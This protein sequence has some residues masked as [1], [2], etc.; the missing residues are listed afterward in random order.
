MKQRSS[1]I[2]PDSTRFD[3]I[4]I[5][6]LIA[7]LISLITHLALLSSKFPDF[8]G[9]KPTQGRD[10]NNSAIIVAYVP[11]IA[12]RSIASSLETMKAN[13]NSRLAYLC[14][15]KYT[16][17]LDTFSPFSRL[18]SL[19]SPLPPTLILF[20]VY[21]RTLEEQRRSVCLL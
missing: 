9:L 10:K 14:S 16:R 18:F 13:Y 8:I 5:A 12:R 4:Q 15:C 2:R 20:D 3:T 1:S 21:V 17:T 6:G 11:I 19:L 7:P